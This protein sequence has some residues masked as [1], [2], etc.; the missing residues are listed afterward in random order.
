M[1][2]ILFNGCSWTYGAELPVFSE[3]EWEKWRYST[4]VANNFRCEH[5]NIAMNGSS[6]DRIVRTTIEELEN[7]KYDLVVVQ[8]SLHERTEINE[9][10][11]YSKFIKLSPNRAK[12]INCEKSILYYRELYGPYMGTINYQKNKY[13]LSQYLKSKNINYFYINHSKSIEFTNPFSVLPQ[14]KDILV[15]KDILQIGDY[16][17]NRHPNIQGHK[18]IANCLI[19][20]IEKNNLL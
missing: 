3:Y 6:N 10:S 11:D 13:L 20:H 14:D 16:C 12:I 18:K 4:I 9:T 5:L 15:L 2:K 7:N 19:D 1:K 17:E 8:W